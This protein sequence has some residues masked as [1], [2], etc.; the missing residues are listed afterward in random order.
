MGSAFQGDGTATFRMLCTPCDRIER[1]RH[2]GYLFA[3][4]RMPIPEP[5]PEPEIEE[6]PVDLLY[7]PQMD[8]F[9]PGELRR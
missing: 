2:Q 4:I 6:E 3:N 5:E 7:S 1:P 9:A 8:L